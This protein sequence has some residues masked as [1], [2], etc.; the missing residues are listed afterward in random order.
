MKQELIKVDGMTCQ[1]CVQT[2]TDVV[3]K[4]P[5][6]ISINVNLDKKEVDVKFDENETSIQEIT[7]K[8]YEIGFTLPEN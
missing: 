1:H 2:I 7:K 4:I 3:K 6:L 8:I 5:G